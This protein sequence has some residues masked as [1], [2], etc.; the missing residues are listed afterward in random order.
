[1]TKIKPIYRGILHFFWVPEDDAA[2]IVESINK[3]EKGVTG[4]DRNAPKMGLKRSYVAWS[5]SITYFET[6]YLIYL[7]IFCFGFFIPAKFISSFF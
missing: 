2:K 7:F 4:D 1:M 5:V 6:P 3:Y